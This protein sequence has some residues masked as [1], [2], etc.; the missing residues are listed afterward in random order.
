[1]VSLKTNFKGAEDTISLLKKI[2]SNQTP[3]PEEI[4]TTFDSDEYKYMCEHH[5][6]VKSGEIA[7]L[8]PNDL[9]GIIES[10]S[11]EEQLSSDQ[12]EKILKIRESFAN[13]I[14]NIDNIE[15]TLLLIKDG[16]V[17]ELEKNING[18]FPEDFQGEYE[19]LFILD[20]YDSV[21]IHNGKLVV[22]L[23]TI[24]GW[25][26]LSKGLANLLFK[27][28]LKGLVR[29]WSQDFDL[30][31]YRLSHRLLL[32]IQLSGILANYFDSED[33]KE[34]TAESDEPLIFNLLIY[35][36]DVEHLLVRILDS[37]LIE[38]EWKKNFFILF[39]DSESGYSVGDE[40]T[41]VIIGNSGEKEFLGALKSPF[42]L[43]DIYN[44]G[45]KEVNHSGKA[46]HYCFNDN[47]VERLMKL[48]IDRE[49]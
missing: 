5:M 42:T 15:K 6:V 39:Y 35:F 1:M 25:K 13:A 37:N 34:S 11:K 23:Y 20:G 29:H 33:T 28:V 2:H 21:Y 16:L 47:V 32:V 24:A 49:K 8:D 26:D 17:A 14:E 38:R 7:N 10:V 41:K 12:D 48:S 40:M 9:V 43:L 31:S 19:I 44:R 36:K 18:Y 3:S 27:F 46:Y 4:K 30:D 45:A 22:D